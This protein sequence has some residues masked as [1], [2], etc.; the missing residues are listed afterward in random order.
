MKLPKRKPED[1]P[2]LKLN[3]EGKLVI[4]P[5]NNELN[6]DWLKYIGNNKEVEERIYKELAEKHKNSV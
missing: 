1:V 3:K 6:D 2:A 4:V 5:S